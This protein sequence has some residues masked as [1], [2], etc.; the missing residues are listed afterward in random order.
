MK[1]DYTRIVGHQSSRE[2]GRVHLLVLHT[3]EGHDA[4]SGNPPLDLV[5]LGALFDSEEASSHFASNR[6]GR[7]ARYV[8]DE[9][10][11]WT[12]CNFNPVSLSLEQIGFASFSK[13]QWFERHE[14]LHAAAEFILYGH[15]H[16]GVPIQAGRVSGGGVARDGVVQH[17]DLGGIGCGHSDCGPG[18]PIGYVILLA[19]YFDAR[20]RNPHSRET[21]RK[22]RKVNRVRRRFSVKEAV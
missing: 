8:E 19:Q 2:G 21:K 13:R 10:K 4:P 14:Q 11:A 22:R 16:H 15:R 1:V 3:T 7:I 20:D 5:G 17:S 18:Y 12:Q 6:D 9:R